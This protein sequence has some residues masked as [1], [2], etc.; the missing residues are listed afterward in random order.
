[1]CLMKFFHN[2]SDYD[3]NFPLK[4]LPSKFEG[5]CEC[6]GGETEKYQKKG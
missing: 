4:E 6:F 1:M 2:G 3:Y 5:K